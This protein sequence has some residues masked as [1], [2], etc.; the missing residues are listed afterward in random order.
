MTDSP[1]CCPFVLTTSFLPRPHY[2]QSRGT[3]PDHCCWISLT[4]NFSF[5]I[6]PAKIFLWAVLPSR[7]LPTKSF[8]P[9]LLS[10][11]LSE[12]TSHYFSFFPIY[13]QRLLLPT[14]L[15]LP[16][17]SWHSL[18]G[19]LE[20]T[21]GIALRAEDLKLTSQS[22]YLQRNYNLLVFDRM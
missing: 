18:L 9:C 1:G 16:I 4:G 6:R 19:W 22:S 2:E 13:P 14:S 5:S 20:L 7:A 8:L 11:L 10:A 12:H 21:W 15:M 3:D 17:L